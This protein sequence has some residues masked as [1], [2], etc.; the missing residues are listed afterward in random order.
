[1]QRSAACTTSCHPFLIRLDHILKLACLLETINHTLSSP[2]LLPETLKCSKAYI[3][4][5]PSPS[6][7]R[8]RI[9]GCVIAQRIACAMNIVPSHPTEIGEEKKLVK[10]DGGLYCRRVQ[11]VSC[12]NPFSWC[13]CSPRL[14]PTPLGIP[15]LFVP[16]NHRRQGI[17]SLLL[18]AAAKTFVHGCELDPTKGEV[19][20]SQ[21]TGDGR[22]VMES[23]GKG[24]VRIYQE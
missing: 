1:M 6:G 19:A 4:L 22:K 3:F 12:I 21:P 9:A 14:Y 8:E 24:G 13:T 18:T 20:F 11:I 23:W 2:A 10:V 17:A 5:V 15:R 16:S 7:T